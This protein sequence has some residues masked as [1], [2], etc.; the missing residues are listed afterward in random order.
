M[1]QDTL[2]RETLIARLAEQ[3]AASDGRVDVSDF[4]RSFHPK[5]MEAGQVLAKE[6]EAYRVRG[7]FI[8]RT[9]EF[10]GYI[11]GINER[12]TP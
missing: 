5:D 10:E 2:T 3:L 7:H 8:A 12:A 4:V 11:T 6:F 1:T 9:F